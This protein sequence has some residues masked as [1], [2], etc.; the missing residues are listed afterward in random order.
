MPS[1]FSA[2]GFSTSLKSLK[3]Q[4]NPGVKR[5]RRGCRVA[6]ISSNLCV[7][8]CVKDACVCVSGV[9]NVRPGVTTSR[10]DPHQTVQLRIF[11]APNEAL[12]G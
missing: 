6:L 11:W 12:G 4:P 2:S 5:A 9:L 7:Y 10:I 8:C 1:P 3:L